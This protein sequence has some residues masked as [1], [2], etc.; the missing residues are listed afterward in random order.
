MVE[1]DDS[2]DSWVKSYKRIKKDGP[3]KSRVQK[4][5]RK[6]QEDPDRIGDAKT[7]KFVGLK[8]AR[9][10]PWV[11]LFEVVRD[12]KNQPTKVVLWMLKHHNDPDYD[13]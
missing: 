11:I 9:A 1:L 10:D 5:L 8:S 7:G 2:R 4:K 13:P 12:D 3:A 6:I